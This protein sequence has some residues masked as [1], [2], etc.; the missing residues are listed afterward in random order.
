VVMVAV[1]LSSIVIADDLLHLC[2]LQQRHGHDRL[3]HRR[4]DRPAQDL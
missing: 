4:I 1:L 3:D 2:R